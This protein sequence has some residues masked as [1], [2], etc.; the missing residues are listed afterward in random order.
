MKHIIIGLG[1]V[2]KALREVLHVNPDNIVAWH[3]RD[4]SAVA[5][6]GRADAM[7]V[8]IPYSDEFVATVKSYILLYRPSVV[9]VHSSVPVGTWTITTGS[10]RP[11]AVCIR[12]S[13][14]ASSHS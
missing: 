14:T 12:T 13:Q 2:G 11:C 1:E 10:T 8:A 7:H 3:D 4:A 5:F 9:I 6:S